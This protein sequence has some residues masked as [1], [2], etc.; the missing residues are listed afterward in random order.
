[1]DSIE[2]ID[3]IDTIASMGPRKT[4][5]DIRTL[6]VV[7]LFPCKVTKKREKSQIYL[8]FSK[9]IVSSFPASL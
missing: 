4:Y 5:T 2:T 9:C 6:S 7:S 8:S 1:M 3:T